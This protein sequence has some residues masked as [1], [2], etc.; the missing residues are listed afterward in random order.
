MI[1]NLIN[2]SE[3]FNTQIIDLL[4][5]DIQ[6]C[7]LDTFYIVYDEIKLNH[8]IEKNYCNKVYDFYFLFSFKLHSKLPNVKI[9]TFTF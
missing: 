5:I 2:I 9:F 6:I 7:I 3:T 4:S 8:S 1:R